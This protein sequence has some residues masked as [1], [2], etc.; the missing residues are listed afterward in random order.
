MGV[1]R[2]RTDEWPALRDI[3]LRALRDAPY[4]FG[5]TF[6]EES[7]R[8][9]DRWIDWAADGSVGGR[10]LTVVADDAGTWIGLA[11]GAPHEAFPG[12][13]GL[14][15]MWVDPTRRSR[16]VGRELVDAVVTWSIGERFPAVRLLVAAANPAAIRLYERCGFVDTGVR[17]PLREGVH[18]LT[19]E[20]RRT[21]P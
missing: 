14:F 17:A 10:G 21:L 19:I 20:M 11:R 13:A 7:A 8:T 1:R 6:E 5:S 4:A 3:R 16:G 2:I 12:E 18:E 9:D 15:S